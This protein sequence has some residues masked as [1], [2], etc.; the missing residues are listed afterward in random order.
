MSTLLT[1]TPRVGHGRLKTG[2]PSCMQT[3]TRVL[4]CNQK[5]N[6]PWMAWAS[7]GLPNKHEKDTL[8]P[9]AAID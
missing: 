3:I 9:I 5:T 6:N 4:A 7:M 8:S 2:D 1:L